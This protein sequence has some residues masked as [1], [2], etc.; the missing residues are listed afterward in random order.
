MSYTPT[1]PR[2]SRPHFPDG[3][4]TPPGDAGLL[5]WSFVEERMTQAKNYWVCTAQPDGRPHATPVWGVWVE[6]RLF[7]DGS[8][9]TRRGRD[10]R[11]NPAVS[12]HLEDGDQVVILE[13]NALI[14][15]GAP[16]P[17]LAQK[18][19]RAYCAKYEA[20]GYAPAPDSWD[21]G[22]LFVFTPKLGFGWTRFPDDTTRW[23][24][25]D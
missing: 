15:A 17:D 24:L 22:G 16:E 4:G 12:V 7:F 1:Q 2:V 25:D 14:L 6:G 23:T 19:S 5:P 21:G 10:I 9:Q 18:I 11:A 13:G 8:P 20:M 3:Y